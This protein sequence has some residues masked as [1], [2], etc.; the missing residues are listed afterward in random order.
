M[1]KFFCPHCGALL[2]DQPGFS[3]DTG[4][5]TCVECGKLLMD[6]EADE[7]LVW[8]CDHC[9]AIL[10]KQ[11]CFT[12]A[13]GKWKCSAC[14]F[15]NDLSDENVDDENT[16]PR[17]RG[18]VQKIRI[19]S[20]GIISCPAPE[21]EVE[22]RLTI[23]KDG[24]VWFSAYCFAEG[25]YQKSRFRAFSVDKQR[26]MRALDALGQFFMNDTAKAACDAGRWNLI[27][28]NTEGRDYQFRGFLTG[29]MLVYG[30]D[31]SDMIRDLTAMRDLFVFDGNS[32]PDR[33]ERLTIDFH[34][35]QIITRHPRTQEEP[36]RC[37]WDR[38]EK[39]VV[40]R[41]SEDIEFIRTL[42]SGLTIRHCY[43]V[44]EGVSD[45]LDRFDANDLVQR[46]AA[47]PD[48]LVIDPDT[49]CEF[50]LTLDMKKSPQKTCTGYCDKYELPVGWQ[51]MMAEIWAFI[52]FYGLGGE[53]FDPDTYQRCRRRINDFIFVYVAFDP[54][55]K[56]YCYL[57]ENDTYEVGDQIDVPVGDA[58]ATSKATITKIRYLPAEEA[59]FP[60]DKIK[61]L[62]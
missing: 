29:E 13:Q 44:Q 55:G 4:A 25:R 12:N 23:I 2:N 21:N 61:K 16:A 32:K 51:D 62:P 36:Q 50:T 47:V 17:F 1:N 46:E 35:Y 33:I 5:W 30:A 8:Y 43:H 49:K 14:S 11:P 53:L 9:G 56:E 7:G 58:H 48:D 27:I 59:P 39:I 34:K 40:A 26:A 15:T 54:D 3:P 22:Q 42:G 18:T 20:N 6:G 24:R 38:T 57:T 31:L 10:N 41:A 45:L 37:I 52:S 19:V 60:L 28:T